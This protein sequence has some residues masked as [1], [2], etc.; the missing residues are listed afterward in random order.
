[1][2]LQ[3]KFL[4]EETSETKSFIGES[5]LL[6]LIPEKE[7]PPMVMKDLRSENLKEFEI[8]DEGI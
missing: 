5:D 8:N 2:K 7:S 3:V 1:M 6:K 4:T